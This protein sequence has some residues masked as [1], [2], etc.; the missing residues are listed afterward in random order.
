VVMGF[1]D[2]PGNIHRGLRDFPWV[3]VFMKKGV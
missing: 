2:V 1:V 3:S